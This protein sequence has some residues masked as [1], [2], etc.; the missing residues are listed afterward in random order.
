MPVWH[1][2]WNSRAKQWALNKLLATEKS[3]NKF[4]SLYIR[5]GKV[6]MIYN[7]LFKPSPYSSWIRWSENS[8][9]KVN[10]FKTEYWNLHGSCRWGN[11]IPTLNWKTQSIVSFGSL[12]HRNI[13]FNIFL[14]R[15][16]ALTSSS[17]INTYVHLTYQ[18]NSTKGECFPLGTLITCVLKIF[19]VEELD[20][21]LWIWNIYQ[22]FVLLLFSITK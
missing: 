13:I 21:V 20:M 15:R 22:P 2:S 5:M 7:I 16:E 9:L 14:T 17:R 19:S 18:C 4:L 1:I 6:P 3:V 11:V 10:P 8:V 12:R